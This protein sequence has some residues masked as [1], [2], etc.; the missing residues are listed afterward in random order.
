MI[1]PTIE[2]KTKKKKTSEQKGKISTAEQ[3]IDES[4]NTYNVEEKKPDIKID[5]SDK[6]TPEK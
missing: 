1:I 3:N 6:S 5:N 4:S 2:E